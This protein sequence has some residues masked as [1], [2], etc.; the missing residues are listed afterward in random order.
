MFRRILLLI[1]CLPAVSF[2]AEAKRNWVMITSDL[3]AT[4]HEYY[5]AIDKSIVDEIASGEF[6]KPFVLGTYCYYYDNA[7]NLKPYSQAGNDSGRLGWSGDVLMRV[8]TIQRIV[9]VDNAYTE[10]RWERQILIAPLKPSST[11]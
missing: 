3:N 5:C 7:S 9:D 10:A 1:L 11:R 8:D 6:S 2:S 4:V